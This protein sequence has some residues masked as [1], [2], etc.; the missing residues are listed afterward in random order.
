MHRTSEEMGRH[1]T[2]LADE[3]KKLKASLSPRM[4]EVLKD[5]RLCLLELL[6]RH[7]GHEDLTLVKGLKRGFDLT[8]A[9]SRSGV[10]S[11]KFRPA[12]M[13]CEGLRKTWSHCPPRLCA[14]LW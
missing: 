4:A 10:F 12:S 9:L 14:E 5:K 13:T 2:D 1:A 6:I 7:S 3:E 8:G 11:Q